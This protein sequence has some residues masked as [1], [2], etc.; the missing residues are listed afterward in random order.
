[1][2]GKEQRVTFPGARRGIAAWSRLHETNLSHVERSALATALRDFYRGLSQPKRFPKDAWTALHTL[3][4]SASEGEWLDFLTAFEWTTGNVAPDMLPAHIR[5]DLIA[6][7]FSADGEQAKE[8][9][10]RLFLHVIRLLS[11]PGEKRLETSEIASVLAAPSDTVLA[12]RVDAVMAWSLQF[13]QR[14]HDVEVQLAGLQQHAVSQ[15]VAEDAAIEA[16]VKW[17]RVS[18]GRFYSV[19]LGR[20]LPSSSAWD[21]VRLPSAEENRRGEEA[22]GKVLAAHSRLLLI[23]GAGAGKSTLCLSLGAAVAERGELALRVSLR[24]TMR[25]LI[26][27]M[28]FAQALADLV[29]SLEAAPAHGEVIAGRLRLLLADGLDEC[30]TNRALVAQKLLEWSRAHDHCRIVVTT[31]AFGGMQELLPDFEVAE[32]LHLDRDAARSLASSLL[33]EAEAPDPNSAWESLEKVLPRRSLRA[34]SPVGEAARNPLLLSFLVALA[35]QGVALDGTRAEVY[36]RIVAA[37][38]ERGRPDR[39]PDAEPSEPVLRF[40]FDALGW[41]FCRT[42]RRICARCEN[43]SLRSW[44]LPRS[45][46]SLRQKSR[47]T[48][49]SGSGVTAECSTA[50]AMA[51]LRRSSLSISRWPNSAPAGASLHFLQLSF[52]RGSKTRS[53]MPDPLAR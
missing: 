3:L 20:H 31:R 18:Y 8:H 36:G 35:A 25:R 40:V 21:R 49:R 34:G 43:A 4:Q 17:S 50:S 24:E 11:T 30:G 2:I 52:A 47:L 27:G 5:S 48:T 23:A 14:L 42:P 29:P 22:A 32:L 28:T 37:I 6:R 41:L 7:G 10:N 16:H 45:C 46:P 19:A 15:N 12:G 44:R 26:S 13:E 51:A 39:V 9:H 53:R 33:N 1:M 38:R